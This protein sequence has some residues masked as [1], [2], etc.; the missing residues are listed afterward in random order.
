MKIL[1]IILRNYIKHKW[2]Y[3]LGTCISWTMRNFELF[4]L[5]KNKH[6]IVR[7]RVLQ[8]NVNLLKQ[9]AKSHSRYLLSVACI[10]LSLEVI[11]AMKNKSLPMWRLL[12]GVP[13]NV[14]P[15]R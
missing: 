2:V 13:H 8:Y 3:K 5:F 9:I 14:L 7:K 15:M 10:F 12:A 11:L 4:K 6:F 1:F